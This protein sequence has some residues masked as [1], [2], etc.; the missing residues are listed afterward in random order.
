VKALLDDRRI[1]AVL[2]VRA[3][4]GSYLPDWRPGRDYRLNYAVS[5]ELGGGILLDAIHELDYL[6]WFFGDVS[7]V[8]GTLEHKSGLAGDTEDLAEI[9]LRFKSGVLAQLHL[10]YFQRTYHRTLKVIGDAGTILW[11][12]SEQSVTVLAPDVATETM[13]ELDGDRNQMYVDELRHFARCLE[14][15]ESPIV[16]G[17]EALRSLRLV[18]AIKR[19][20]RKDRW[21]R[22]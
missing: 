8:S 13:K 22:I 20:S 5:S 1:G 14:S 17:R 12:F 18:D 11:D 4:F 21:E 10:D 15:N 2:S 19:S 9:T 16:D 7:E 6:S 3:E